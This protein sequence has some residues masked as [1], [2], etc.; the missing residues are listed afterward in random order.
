MIRISSGWTLLL[1]IFIPVFYIVFLIAIAFATIKAGDEVNPLFET[2]FY[3]IFIILIVISGILFFRYTTWRLKRLDASKDYFY[4]TDYF[5]TFRY[6][7]D[8]IES[9]TPLRFLWFN[10]LKIE[11]KEKGSL[12][13]TMIVLIE[14]KIWNQY[15][16]NHGE[17]NQLISLQK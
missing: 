9:I 8:S 1:K 14:E 3:R 15:C 2:W 12:G 5:K 10:F 16:T 11:L 4:I 7:L 17:V 6:T 13:K